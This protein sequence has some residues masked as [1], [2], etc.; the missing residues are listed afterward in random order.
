MAEVVGL[1]RPV[2]EEFALAEDDCVESN[3]NLDELATE[4]GPAGEGR[5]DHWPAFVIRA[6]P[7]RLNSRYDDIDVAV[8]WDAGGE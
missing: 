3:V 7:R 8:D 6:V 5:D 1:S 2:A 4:A